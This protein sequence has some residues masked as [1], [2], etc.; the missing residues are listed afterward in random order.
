IVLAP[1]GYSVAGPEGAYIYHAISAHADVLDVS[2]TSP[3]PGDVI[4]TVLS[5]SA[6]GQPSQ[7]VLDAVMAAVNQES[8]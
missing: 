5:R 7:D 2:A 6:N 4:I 3:T 1:E 8:V